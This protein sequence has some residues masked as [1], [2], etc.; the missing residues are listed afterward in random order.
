MIKLL[1]YLFS[2]LTIISI[3]LSNPNNNNSISLVRNNSVFSFQSGQLFIQKFIVFNI[4]MFLMC[5]ILLL[6]IL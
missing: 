5:T 2:L 6:I 3:L 1:W 4:F